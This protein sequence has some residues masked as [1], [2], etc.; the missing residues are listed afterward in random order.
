M[1]FFD[2]IQVGGLRVR[3]ADT[4]YGTAASGG[5]S[6]KKAILL[7]HG[8]GGS[9]ES[10]INNFD[11]LAKQGL[12][13]IA[14]DLPGFGQSD[15]PKMD[16]TVKFYSDFV[17]RFVRELKAAPLAVAGSSLGAHVA[18]ELAINHPGIVSRLVLISPPGALPR[19]FAG[20]PALRRYVRVLQAR[21]VEQVKKALAAVDNRPVA[22]D[23]AKAVY[24]KLAMPGA[25]EAFLSA[26]AGTARAPRLT[27]R[28]HLIKAPTLLIWGQQDIMIPVKFAE[29]FIKK[30]KSCRA[31]L[32]E[33]C[34]HRPHVDKAAVFNHLVAGFVHEECQ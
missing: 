5:S 7:I 3:Y 2:F 16:Y 15:K 10:W 34:G 29:P 31:V 22:D 17:A 14:L 27:P 25:K 12:R 19:S 24:E 1:D 6:K 26:L 13:V 20:T 18:A 4:G 33:N 30:I 32:L 21:D 23:Y 9:I 11:A 8:L 28:L